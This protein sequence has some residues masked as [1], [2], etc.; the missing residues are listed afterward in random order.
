MTSPVL[1]YQPVGCN[2]THADHIRAVHQSGDQLVL[3]NTLA[4]LNKPSRAEVLC[5]DNF[6]KQQDPLALPER[7]AECK[8]DMITIKGQRD[9]AVL[10]RLIMRLLGRLNNAFIRVSVDPVPHLSRKIRLRC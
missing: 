10:D 5:L 9:E 4:N 8:D 2:I 7:Y 6:F 3:S 1:Y